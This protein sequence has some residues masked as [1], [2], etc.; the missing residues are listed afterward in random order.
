MKKIIN[1]KIYNTE[2]AKKLARFESHYN[3]TDL[4]YFEEE[5]YQKKTGEFFLYGTGNAASRYNKISYGN[6]TGAEKI[7]PLS[8]QEAQD[9]AEQS[10][11]SEKYINIFG[12]PKEDENSEKQCLNLYMSSVVIEKI[13]KEAA[14]KGISTSEYITKMIEK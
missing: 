7:I 4:N 2:T 8:Y 6:Y 12:E 11:D 13:K 9:W 3:P 5:L 14:K 1:G 10:L